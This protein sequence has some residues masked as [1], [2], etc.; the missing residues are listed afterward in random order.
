MS[1]IPP[2]LASPLPRMIRIARIDGWSIFGVAFL[3][4]VISIWQGELTGAVGGIIAA[5][6][7]AVEVYGARQLSLR[8]IEG[9]GWLVASQL[10]LLTAIDCYCAWKLT[11][12]AIGALKASLPG[13]VGELVA[14]SGQSLDELL[15]LVYPLTYVT[16]AIVSLF[17]QGGMAFYYLRKSKTLSAEFEPSE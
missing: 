9:L 1:E 15:R 6:A 13:F 7:G 5:A 11:H 3:F 14:S 10:G 17:Y 2:L 12:P 8:K 16:L 4:G